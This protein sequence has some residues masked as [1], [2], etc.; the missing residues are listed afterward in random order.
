MGLLRDIKLWA[1]SRRYGPQRETL[2]YPKLI[3]LM[4][5]SKSLGQVKPTPS[6]LR[7][8]SR[9]PYARRAINAIKQPITS[10]AWEVVPREDYA[11]AKQALADADIITRCLD[12]PNAQDSLRSLLEQ[13]IEDVLISGSGIIEQAVSGYASLPLWLWPVDALTVQPLPK[14]DG[15][16]H[17]PR[18]VQGVGY[19]GGSLMNDVT[20][21]KLEAQ[22][23]VCIRLN[24]ATDSPSGWGPLE[25]AYMS[26][27]RQLGVATYAANVASNAQPE[28]M[29]YAGQAS[30]EEIAAF[31]TYWRNEIEGQGQTPIIGNTIKPDVLKLHAGG[32]DALYLKWQ[33][34]LIR[35]LATSF[36]LSPQNLGLESDVNRNT[37]EVAEDRDWDGAIKPMAALIESHINTDIL[38]MRLGMPHLM[39]R[40][41]GIDREDEAATAK[42]YQMYYANNAITPDE[43]RARLGLPPMK[44]TWGDKTWADVQIAL[45]AAQGSKQVDDPDLPVTAPPAIPASFGG[46]DNGN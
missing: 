11:K 33:A 44:S 2:A 43:Q 1:A 17:S 36:G 37:A 9:T 41:T 39:F 38:A 12:R 29:I 46:D 25:I 45:K 28:N 3:S 31:R 42:I 5:S 15:Q 35:E 13:V 7:Y 16:P 23:I 34:F 20:A 26:V 14:W 32:D 30:A 4:G 22:D 21:R 19:A 27:A 24:P 18:Y 40:F 6:N 8:F 10:L